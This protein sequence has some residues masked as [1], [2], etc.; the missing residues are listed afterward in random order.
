MPL[1][2]MSSRMPWPDREASRPPL[3]SGLGREKS[4]VS[5]IW[6]LAV[7]L[8]KLI[9]NHLV[10]KEVGEE[11][12]REPEGERQGTFPWV[13]NTTWRGHRSTGACYGKRS[14]FNAQSPDLF[15]LQS[16]VMMFLQSFPDGLHSV[17]EHYAVVGPSSAVQCTQ[18]CLVQCPQCSTCDTMMYQGSLAPQ[19]ALSRE[20]ILSACRCSRD[21]LLGK[22]RSYRAWGRSLWW[23]GLPLF[24]SGK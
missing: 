3:P 1:L 15:L 24:E 6:R 23:V 20:R 10:A 16:I 19:P 7:L 12:R 11:R 2:L 17:L 21:F 22:P 14:M 9:V 4:S 18:R 8:I 5:F 13:N